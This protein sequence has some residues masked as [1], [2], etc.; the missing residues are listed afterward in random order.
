MLKQ[1][2]SKHLLLLLLLVFLEDIDQ[3]SAKKRR[4]CGLEDR[5]CSRSMKSCW[6]QSRTRNTKTCL[7]AISGNAEAETKQT[8]AA[9][10]AASIPGRYRSKKRQEAAQLRPRGPLMQQIYEFLLV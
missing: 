1:K 3:N 8:P 10:A 6:F 7:S 9:A 2:P 4:S 5:S